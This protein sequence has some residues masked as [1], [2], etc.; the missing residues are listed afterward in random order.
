VS[1]V[2]R[3][4][5]L[6]ELLSIDLLLPEFEQKSSKE[7]LAQRLKNRKSLLLIACENDKPIAYKLGYELSSKEFYSWL[8]GVVPDYRKRGVAT[9]LREAQESWAI[10]NGYS[11]ISVKSMNQFPAMLQLLIASDYQITGYE[12]NGTLESSKIKFSKKLV[13]I[14][15]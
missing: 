9:K 11:S 7:N 6:E 10:E 15:E 3:E 12:D 2:I 14:N 4:G 5:T 8:G 1:F 13:N